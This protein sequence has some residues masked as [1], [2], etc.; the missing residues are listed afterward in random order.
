MSEPITTAAPTQDIAPPP[1][2]VTAPAPVQAPAPPVA[3]RTYQ[4]PPRPAPRGSGPPR[5]PGEGRSFPR[6][7]RPKNDGKPPEQLDRRDFT[8]PNKRL[9]DQSIE[10][11]MAAAMEGMDVAGMLAPENQQKPV[12]AATAAALPGGRKRGIIVAMRNN[13]IFVDV[14]GGRSQGMLPRD[15]FT[16]RAPA[17]GDEVDFTVERY[18]ASNGLLILTREGSVQHVTD[19]SSL[20]LHMIVEAKVTGVNKN[21]TGL[22]VEVNG[23]KGFMPISQIDLY[24][25]EQPDQFVGQKLKCEVIELDRSERNLILSRR[26]MLERERALLKEEF[27]AKVDVGQTHTGTVSSLQKFGVFVNLGACDGLIP[28]SE[29][30]WS[31]VADASEIVKVGQKVDVVI[32]RLDRDTRKIALSLKQLHG[33][34]WEDF[35]KSNRA[36]ARLTGKV[37]R[38]ADFG[39]FV[40]LAPGIEGLIHISE[41]STSRVRKVTDVV[42][43]GQMVDVQVLTIE[44]QVRRIALSLKTIMAGQ[45]A[46]DAA[47]AE[48]ERIADLQAAG[49]RIASRP[50]N[51]NLRGGIGSARPLFEG[52]EGE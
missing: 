39:A 49:E 21:A 25:V 13:D 45:E 31:R 36:G 27:W 20:S 17:I 16:D 6:S 4:G 5:G 26:A 28:M 11:E 38:I 9:L 46:I 1:V 12:A 8:K 2:A 3:G 50:V 40:E 42:Q 51:P 44:P 33:N 43:E 34:P 15:Q 23:I 32:H 19:M 30:S 7:D 29:L 52:G 22:M 41:L 48:A 47:T 10:A 35:T 14:P 18:D 37:T 24:R